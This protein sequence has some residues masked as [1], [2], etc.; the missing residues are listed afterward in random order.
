[1]KKVILLAAI[2]L[3]MILVSN[4]SQAQTNRFGFMVG[5]AN[6]DFDETGIGAL[7]EFKVMEKGAISPQLIFYFPGND[8][9]LFE[10][11]GNFDYYFYDQDV[12]EFYGL[13]GLNFTRVSWDDDNGNDGSESELGLNIGAGINFD[14]GKKVAPFAEMRFTIGEY[15]QFVLGLGLKIGLN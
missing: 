11:N 12:I 4:D 8:V 7:G 3:A 13:A 15:D 9:T 1:M 6:G 5:F 2:V 10:L 14:L